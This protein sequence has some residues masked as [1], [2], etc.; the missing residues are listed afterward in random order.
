MGAG[1]LGE[2]RQRR[3]EGQFLGPARVD[4][5]QQRVDDAV[6]DFLAEPGRHVAGHRHIAVA[7]RGGQVR[8]PPR[9]GQA[10]RRQHAGAGQVIEIRGHSHHLPG[11]SPRSTP[12]L[13]IR[14]AVLPGGTRSP[15]RPTARI[16]PFPRQAGQQR[17]GTRVNRHPGHLGHGQLPAQPGGSFQDGHRHRLIPQEERR[18]Q[19]GDTAADDRDHGPGPWLLLHSFTLKPLCRWAGGRG[20]AGGRAAEARPVVRPA[21]GPSRGGRT[22][23][24]APAAGLAEVRYRRP[25]ATLVSFHAHPDD[26]CIACGG[27]IRKA[28]EEGHRV[29]LV[30]ATRGEQ[31]E[32]PDGFLADGE[33]LWERRVAETQASA[34]ILGAQRTE[35]LGYRD[36]G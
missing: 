4:A 17:L 12:R 6:H 16:S 3:V 11:G 19:P 23:Q 13:Q 36:S 34:A 25:M 8:L 18:R 24:R 35:F 29:V 28:A 15:S 31:G 14:G 10:R 32:V 1:G 21:S 33:Q 9:P 2:G 20:Q 30:V 27:V 26:E 7:P 22:D 5:A